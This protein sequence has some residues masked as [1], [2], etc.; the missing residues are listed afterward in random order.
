[1]ADPSQAKPDGQPNAKHQ[2]ILDMGLMATNLLCRSGDCFRLLDLALFKVIWR[3]KYSEKIPLST[4]D[5]TVTLTA[6]D[7][8]RPWATS[9]KGSSSRQDATS[10]ESITKTG[11]AGRRNHYWL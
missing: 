3:K 2:S 5:P 10:I 9:N 11:L 7:R 1:L 6:R 8:H 4:I